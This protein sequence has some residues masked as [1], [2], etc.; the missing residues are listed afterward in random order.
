[1]TFNIPYH[2]HHHLDTDPIDPHSH[3]VTYPRVELVNKLL[4][5]DHEVRVVLD[6]PLSLEG[7]LPPLR[8]E[9]VKADRAL[10]FVLLNRL[11]ELF[12]TDVQILVQLLELVNLAREIAHSWN[13][14]Y[15]SYQ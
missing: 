15:N 12:V 11:L 14:Y 6:A 7:L 8:E 4:A 2:D 5:R 1:M 3:F 9:L 10:G 13:L